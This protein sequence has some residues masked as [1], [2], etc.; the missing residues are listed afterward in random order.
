MESFFNQK[1]SKCIVLSRLLRKKSNELV[2]I[3]VIDLKQ[4]KNSNRSK[5]VKWETTV[6]KEHLPDIERLILAENYEM[7]RHLEKV[8]EEADVKKKKK[9]SFTKSLADIEVEKHA[10]SE[11][12]NLVKKSNTSSMIIWFKHK[13]FRY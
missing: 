9:V 3:P 7:L 6:N 11:W 8:S 13:R 4:L 10:E 12:T 1:I 2:Q 5:F